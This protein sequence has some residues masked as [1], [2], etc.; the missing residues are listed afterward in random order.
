M[1]SMP[2]KIRKIEE[3][4]AE[5]DIKVERDTR[6][7]N[8]D[9]KP[10]R[11]WHSLWYSKVI[12]VIL[13]AVIFSSGV[14]GGYYYGFKKGLS[15]TK[16]INI[17][18][19]AGGTTP[20][21]VT[22]D[23]SEFWQLWDLLKGS[24]VD[25]KSVSDQQ[26]LYG[27]MSGLAGAYNDPYT[28]YFDP[29]S[30]NEFLGDVNGSFGGIGA[31]LGSKEGQLIIIAPLKDT[32]AAAAGLQAQ[33]QIL[34]IDST[35]T[36]NMT[37]DQA[38]QLIRGDPGTKVDLTIFR[39][40]WSQPKVITITR[41]V[42]NVP[43]VD[44]SIKDGDVLYLQLDS[45]DANA[46]Q[47]FG[48]AVINGLLKGAHGMVLD[49][50]DDPG[51]YLD[52]AVNIAG[53]FL[54]PGSVVV[55]ERYADG[56]ETILTAEGNAALK[57]FPVVILINGGSASAS[58]ILSGA[59]RVDRGVKLIGDKSFGKGSVQQ[60][61]QFLDGSAAKITI[62]KWLLPDGSAIDKVGLVPD[63][64]VSMSATDTQADP[65]LAKALQVLQG[66][67]SGANK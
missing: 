62:A 1:V 67:M 40:S 49:L 34:D 44:S 46:S 60:V 16:T 59:L 8:T 17:T 18:G 22:A 28:V 51:G 41:A 47:L 52:Q 23:F 37:I 15:Q 21:N 63:Y 10:K 42:I 54:N 56:T 4:R 11:R 2:G 39:D 5:I 30:A 29:K 64:N 35:S 57:N 65:Q 24:Q 61:T 19:I 66:E 3:E 7:D 32:P 12:I 58:E 27:A 20:K 6:E 45:F 25:S 36:A 26:L 13:L 9:V 31:E 14:Y 50:R 53:W 43:T 33:D 55:K 38:V 48:S